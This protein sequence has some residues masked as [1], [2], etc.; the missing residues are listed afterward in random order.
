MTLFGTCDAVDGAVAHDHRDRRKP[1]F[2]DDVVGLLVGPMFV[3][4]EVLMSAGLLQRMRMGIE[5]Q[6]GAAR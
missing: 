1:A 2:V 3:V 5:H 6:A 4:A